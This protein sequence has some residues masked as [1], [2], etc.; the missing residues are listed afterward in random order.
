MHGICWEF[1]LCTLINNT[2]IF[3]LSTVLISSYRP[4]NA[5]TD[6]DIL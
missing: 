3:L 4:T 2:D 5:D 6:G 1:E